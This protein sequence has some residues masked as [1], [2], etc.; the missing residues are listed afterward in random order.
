MIFTAPQW[1][2]VFIV[3]VGTATD[4]FFRRIP[5]WI[6]MPAVMVALIYHGLV[7]G[8][9]GGIRYSLA[10]LAVGCVLLFPVFALGG[11]G[12]GDVKLLGALGAWLGSLD[13][14]N[15]F[16]FSAWAGALGAILIMAK[17][18]TLVPT[19]KNLWRVMICFQV[20][21]RMRVLRGS[22][23][24]M[25]YALAIAAGYSGFLIHGRLV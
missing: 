4:L 17:N 12:G 24:T 14:L 21:G 11:M 18:R 19:M 13:V 9:V 23:A 20:T 15:I 1:V 10:G 7:D 6:T 2:C 3:A 16:F 22:G 25:P 8:S 5:N